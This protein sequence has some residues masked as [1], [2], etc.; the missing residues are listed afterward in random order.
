[1][2]L[3]AGAAVRDICPSRPLFLVGYPHVPRMS[4]GVH[5]PLY[6]SALCIE[7][8]STT[9]IAVAIDTLFITHPLAR[10]CRAAINQSTGVPPE[11]ILLTATHTHS[12]P[13]T[14]TILA[15]KNDPI[16]PPPDE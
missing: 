4:T 10:R 1:M 16:V 2:T 7:N 8:E 15:W 11:H 5:D 6:A 3:T 12:A 9:L 13:S 14:A